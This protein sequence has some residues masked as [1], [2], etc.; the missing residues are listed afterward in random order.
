MKKQMLKNILVLSIT[1]LLMG[2]LISLTHLITAPTIR[3]NRDAKVIQIAEKAYPNGKEFF[4]A[5]DIPNDY[6]KSGAVALTAEE[7]EQL[8]DYLFIFSESKEYLGVLA[9][10]KGNGFGGEI[11]LAIAINRGGLIESVSAISHLETTGY[12][13][14]AI[15]DYEIKYKNAELDYEAEVFAGATITS[16]ALNAIIAEV[17]ANY[18]TNKPVIEKIVELKAI[19]VDPVTRIFGTITETL[20]PE[21]VADAIVLAR[22]NLEGTRLSGYSY[23]A[24]S[25]GTKLKLYLDQAGVIKHHQVLEFGGT[26]E[27]LEKVDTYLAAFADTSIVDVAATIAAN[28]ELTAGIGEALVTAIN[29]MLTKV[30]ASHRQTDP[31]FK[32][33]GDYSRDKDET[34]TATAVLVE[35]Y[36]YNVDGVKKGFSIVGDKSRRFEAYGSEIDGNVKLELIMDLEFKIIGYKFLEYN[37][38][39]DYQYS[40]IEYLDKFIGTNAKDISVTISEN[41]NLYAG[42]SETGRYIIDVILVAIEAEV[43]K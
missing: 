6:K 37:H 11:E 23:E 35:S 13:D 20:D 41:R 18:K 1:A 10:G 14:K 5:G 30:R 19:V 32:L 8:A 29:E 25:G 33:L 36:E 24:V 42:S 2:V 7:E 27:V 3:K 4:R 26:D 38:S 40:I 12:G 17:V 9:I 34:F 39:I 28:T 16:K 31:L 15:A 43:N 22:N 21:F